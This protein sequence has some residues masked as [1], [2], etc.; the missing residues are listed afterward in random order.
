MPPV[1]SRTKRLVIGETRYE[2]GRK[3]KAPLVAVQCSRA[4][5]KPR[6]VG[7]LVYCFRNEMNEPIKGKER[8]EGSYKEGPA[9][10]VHSMR[11]F[12]RSCKALLDV[13][14]VM[15][16]NC[17]SESV[18]AAGCRDDFSNRPSPPICCCFVITMLC[19]AKERQARA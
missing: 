18:D 9:I 10:V 8:K 1:G 2:P 12:A 5:Q 6:A 3:D 16:W 7:G 4:I 15:L 11:Y 14:I 17:S 19:K 13:R